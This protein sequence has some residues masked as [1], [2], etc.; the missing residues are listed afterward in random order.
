M[1]IFDHQLVE[2]TLNLEEILARIYPLAASVATLQLHKNA[3]HSM[4]LYITSC[5][6]GSY[7][8]F[9][10]HPVHTSAWWMYII[11]YPIGIYPWCNIHLVHTCACFGK[12][13][14]LDCRSR[15]YCIKLKWKW[16]KILWDKAHFIIALDVFSFTFYFIY[17]KICSIFGTTAPTWIWF[18]TVYPLI[19]YSK[20]Y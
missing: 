2:A 13:S 15:R 7:P 9:N 17:F 11:F 14:S 16:E 4:W 12:Y 19:E 10:I 6:I 8:W 3:D 1:H 5:T 20:K 18:C